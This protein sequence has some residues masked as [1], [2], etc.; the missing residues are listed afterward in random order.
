LL[1]Q[2]DPA[3]L[4][5]TGNVLSP[6]PLVFIGDHAGAAI[7]E[8][9]GTLGLSPGDRAR[10]IAVD[11]GIEELGVTLSDRIDGPFL[12]QSYSRLVIDCNRDPAHATSVA[13]VSDKTIVPG[14]TGIRPGDR[15][16]R[17]D[18][19][20]APYQDAVAAMLDAR[21]AAGLQSILVSLHSFTPRMNE[22]DR[23]WHLGVLHDGQE[24]A[25]CLAVLDRLRR[26]GPYVVG[27]NEPYRMNTTDYTVPRHAFSRGLRYLEL[28]VRQDLIG[29]DNDSGREEIASMLAQ[30]L[31]ACA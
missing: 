2:N 6:G 15:Q 26:L 28:E 16:A 13:Q 30:V 27:D 8:S 23:P 12:R 18:E 3:P 1:G 21:A 17:I 24:D 5:I 20:F 10:H 19:I 29:P 31:P 22:S 14:N 4:R 7:P 11:I 9:L 25:Y